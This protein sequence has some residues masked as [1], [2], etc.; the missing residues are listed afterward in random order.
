MKHLGQCT[1]GDRQKFTD[2]EDQKVYQKA[3][4][5]FNA[6]RPVVCEPGSGTAI[7]P[8]VQMLGEFLDIAPC[9]VHL[10]LNLGTQV[11]CNSA[12]AR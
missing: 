12:G 2:K 8:D 1:S 3:L 4:D 5:G 10:Q 11:F 7:L 6:L 9:D